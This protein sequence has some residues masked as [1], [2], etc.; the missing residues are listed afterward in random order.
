MLRD[1]AEAGIIDVS[2]AINS[3][4]QG[5]H[6]MMVL[7]QAADLAAHVLKEVEPS[8]CHRAQLQAVPAKK[9]LGVMNLHS[10]CMGLSSCTS[11]KRKKMGMTDE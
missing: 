6:Y 5:V 10:G 2:K 8:M 3:Q 1:V 7:G 9:A 11:H 4:S